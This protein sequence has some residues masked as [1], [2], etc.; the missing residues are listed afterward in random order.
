VRHG[1][2]ILGSL[3]LL[4]APADSAA[5]VRY[6]NPICW[7]EARIYHP[8]GADAVEIE[9]AGARVLRLQHVTGT[10]GHPRSLSPSGGYAFHYS[11]HANAGPPSGSTRVSLLVFKEK[12]YL[13]SVEADQVQS[14]QHA[15]WLNE[16]LVSFRLWLGRLAG[17][18]VLLDVEEERIVRMEAF[19]DGRILWEQARESCKAVPHIAACDETC[20]SLK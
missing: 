8:G 13:L 3:S 15:R 7:K 5:S 19:R 2:A 1:A 11:E 14:L 10:L 20:T 4:V 18:D 17:V 16:K 9:K 12:D 6:T